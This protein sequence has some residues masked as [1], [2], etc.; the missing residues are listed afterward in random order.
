MDIWD[1]VTRI[2]DANEVLEKNRRAGQELGKAVLLQAAIEDYVDSVT[3]R[4]WEQA[5]DQLASVLVA[6]MNMLADLPQDDSGPRGR[7]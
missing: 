1:E 3:K 7:R 2:L 6:A 5:R 4:D